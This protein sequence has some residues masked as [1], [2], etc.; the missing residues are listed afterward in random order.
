MMAVSPVVSFNVIKN[1]AGKYEIW[2][3]SFP[4]T[5]R[6]W[7]D[8]LDTQTKSE[9]S[10]LSTNSTK[11]ARD[12]VR[13]ITLPILMN[14]WKATSALII[15]ASH[16]SATVTA[17]I[18]LDRCK[19]NITA[20]REHCACMMEKIG[21]YSSKADAIAAQSGSTYVDSER[22]QTIAT[23]I[24]CTNE[25]VGHQH[26]IIWI[27]P[28]SGRIIWSCHGAATDVEADTL[29]KCYCTRDESPYLDPRTSLIT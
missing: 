17:S 10:Y 19:K 25:P 5:I 12:I 23:Y 21:E 7:N 15:T 6:L 18:I 27:K 9:L 1:E 11:T 20:L 24:Q 26:Q 8:L 13:E 16:V 4:K 29:A 14:T 3:E 28:E 22:N 2:R